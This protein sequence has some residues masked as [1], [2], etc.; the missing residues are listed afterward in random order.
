MNEELKQE[1]LKKNPPNIEN[2]DKESILEDEIFDYLIAL[3]NS[4]DKTRT[5]EKIRT[6][7]REFKVISAFNSIYKQKNQEYIQ[8][9][10]SRGGN[11]FGGFFK[12]II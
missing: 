5:I 9:L 6:K 12:H 4:P 11:Y 3:P 1:M 7:A 8:Y 2:L 10:K